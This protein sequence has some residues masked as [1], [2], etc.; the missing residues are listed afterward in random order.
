MNFDEEIS[1]ALNEEMNKAFSDCT[2]STTTSNTNSSL[3]IED[4]NKC[5]EEIKKCHIE[6][7]LLILHEDDY[8]AVENLL[9]GVIPNEYWRSYFG[10]IRFGLNDFFDVKFSD[11]AFKPMIVLD[12]SKLKW[13]VERDGFEI[14]PTQ[15]IMLDI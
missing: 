5:M 4:V 13:N 15:I 2:Y 10:I 3:T 6:K 12:K 11:I 8:S 1:K 7:M 14:S 9:M